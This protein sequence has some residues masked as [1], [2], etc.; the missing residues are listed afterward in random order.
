MRNC[1]SNVGLAMRALG[2][3][4][5]SDEAPVE[6]TYYLFTQALYAYQLKTGRGPGWRD[7]CQLNPDA[8]QRPWRDW[9]A[10]PNG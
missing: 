9:S 4:N 2:L 3:M 8:G 1:L 10:N 6:S 5:L 7:F